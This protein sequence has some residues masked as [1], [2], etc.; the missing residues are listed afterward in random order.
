V[1]LAAGQV[2]RHLLATLSYARRDVVAPLLSGHRPRTTI[3][4]RRL[5]AFGG[6]LRLLGPMLRSRRE[7]RARQQV[8]DAELAS[9]WVPR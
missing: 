4:R 1:R 8:P 2:A 5:V 3:V 7:L 9:W 6:F